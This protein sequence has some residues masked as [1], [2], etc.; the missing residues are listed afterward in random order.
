MGQRARSGSTVLVLAL[1]VMIGGAPPAIAADVIECAGPFA[2][3]ASEASLVE[4]F[5]RDRVVADTIDG[6]EGSTFEATI[7]FPDN[8][9]R[10][11]AVLWHDEAGRARPAAILV[12]DESR[13]AAPGGI[14]LG[15][16]LA[17]V[18]AANGEPFNLSGFGWDYGG[19]AGFQSGKLASLPGG[20]V[21]G[22]TFDVGDRGSD[23]ISGDMQLSS[24][25]PEVQV[26]KPTVREI[27]IG[28]PAE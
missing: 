28:Y 13:W 21:I 24:S 20:C 5:G 16:S 22:L 10:R 4:A 27:S 1:L 14:T 8:L 12:R 2:R 3:D 15:M 7:L 18:E 26:A 23:A 25:D 6:P 11:L 9:N 17:E 19:S